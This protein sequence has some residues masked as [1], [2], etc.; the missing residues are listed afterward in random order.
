MQVQINLSLPF[1]YH[2]GMPVPLFPFHG[3]VVL[4]TDP[5]KTNMAITIGTPSGVRLEILQ[6]RA[7]GSAYD[8]SEYCVDFVHFLREH[9][10]TCTIVTF[11]IE[12]AISKNGM[13][14]HR[15]SMVLT[16]IRANLISLSYDLTGKKPIEV[17]NWSWKAAILPEGMRGQH[18][19]GST[20]FLPEVYQT[21]G[22]DDVTD[23]ICIYMWLIRKFYPYASELLSPDKSEKPLAP[24]Q[25]TIT[26]YAPNGVVAVYNPALSFD[27]NCA[28]CINRTWKVCVFDVSLDNI[29]L[30]EI[31]K[32]AQAFSIVYTQ[33]TGKV[34]VLRS[35]QFGSS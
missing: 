21:Y 18:E 35:S 13:N 17:N 16:E 26:P 10:K 32:H 20:R 19:K 2:V 22:N 33:N 34:V 8:N 6:F 15:S 1:E 23:S 29:P 12:A 11:G 4:A 9:L 25:V 5:S 7:P 27:D 14:H 28:F 30:E 31:Y 24:Y 3:D